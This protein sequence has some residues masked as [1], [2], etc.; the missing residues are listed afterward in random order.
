MMRDVGIG[1]E[2]EFGRGCDLAYPVAEGP[3]LAGPA[4]GQST[5]GDDPEAILMALRGST[6]DVRGA[7]TTM[8]VDQHD[9]EFAAIILCQQRGDRL[10]DHRRF[11]ARGNDRDDSGAILTPLRRE[12]GEREG[13]ARSVGG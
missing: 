5:C 10:P 7:V 1:E 13:P 3:E 8:I 4:L 2:I 9:R 12:A 11:I 6:R